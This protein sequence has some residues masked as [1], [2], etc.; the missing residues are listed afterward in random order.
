MSIDT[1]VNRLPNHTT[2][3]T[4]HWSVF[5][6]FFVTFLE[7]FV[8][9]VE[10]CS[11]SVLF[12]WATHVH[13]A[14]TW[15]KRT[16]DCKI[17]ADK[18]DRNVSI[19]IAQ[20]ECLPLLIWEKIPQNFV[21]ASKGISR[22]LLQYAGWLLVSSS[23]KTLPSSMRDLFIK[24]ST[25]DISV[26]GFSSRRINFFQTLPVL[27]SGGLWVKYALLDGCLY[28]I[29]TEPSGFNFSPTMNKRGTLHCF[30][31]FKIIVSSVS[32]IVFATANNS[33]DI[34]SE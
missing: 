31:K 7:K 5:F 28:K 12:E 9:C 14:I 6:S 3:N 13:K 10:F 27:T 19:F 11:P 18:L 1:T 23:A 8:D 17:T 29:T 24:S 16:H 15:L 21:K 22:K 30:G 34:F 33:D 2:G 4:L 20:T 32:E 25:L 26:G